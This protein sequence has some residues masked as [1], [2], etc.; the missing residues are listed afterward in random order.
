[1]IQVQKPTILKL[2]GSV[3]T[4]KEKPLTANLKA[5]ERL[6]REISEA[7][8]SRLILIHG[9]G[10]FGHPLAKQY[11][12]KEGYK[13]KS[14][15][16]GFSKTRQAMVNLNKLVVDALIRQ[17]VAAVGLQ[18]SAFVVT[19][20][21]RISC[22]EEHPLR[23]LLEIGLVPVL[24]GDAVFDFDLGFTILS[25]DQLAAF[26]AMQLG[27]SQIILGIDVDGLYTSDP[28]SAPSARLI[29]R[30]T[31]QELRNMQH[32]IEE[33][34]VTDVTRGMLGKISELIP[35]VEKG[36]PALIV[37]AAKPSNIYKALKGEKVTGTTIVKG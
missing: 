26:L 24:Y 20:S 1:M 34:K 23:K 19:S 25:G 10:S 14:Q 8:V 18:P 2:G 6:S 35:A 27:A 3:I 11:V 13:E 37:N 29:R 15:L 28:K 4:K 33:T 22:I 9:G 30:I 16:L 5:V 31:L 32:E 17:N 7:K 36:I 12:L 21:G